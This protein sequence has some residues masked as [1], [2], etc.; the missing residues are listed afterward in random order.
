MYQLVHASRDIKVSKYILK[1]YKVVEKKR[2]KLA[3]RFGYV[4]SDAEVAQFLEL[5]VSLVS[6][7]VCALSL[8]HISEPTRH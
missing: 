7:A 3:Q 5:E 4:P 6:E 8:I 1:L 2:Y